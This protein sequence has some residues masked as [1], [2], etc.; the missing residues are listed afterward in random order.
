MTRSAFHDHEVNSFFK[1]VLR[2]RVRS[3]CS[4]ADSDRTPL[5]LSCKCSVVL[6]LTEVLP[7]VCESINLMRTI[8]AESNKDKEGKN[9]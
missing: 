4:N 9:Q 2:C 8:F 7:R 6:P 3:W 5:V 1:C